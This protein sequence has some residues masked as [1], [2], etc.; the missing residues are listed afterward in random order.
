ML[1]ACRNHDPLVGT[2]FMTRKPSPMGK[3]E[4]NEMKQLGRT[5]LHC[6]KEKY[7]LKQN[8]L[9]A[10]NNLQTL[11]PFRDVIGFSHLNSAFTV[12]SFK[13]FQ[14][15]PKQVKAVIPVSFRK[16][17]LVRCFIR[18]IVRFYLRFMRKKLSAELHV[19]VSGTGCELALVNF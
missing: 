7:W 1:T 17:L 4:L 8:Q 9:I 16:L 3:L 6:I 10:K 2:S 12:H 19:E 11:I 18:C 14:I 15:N 13:L 5:L